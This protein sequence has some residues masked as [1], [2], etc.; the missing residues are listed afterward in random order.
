MIDAT[1]TQNYKGSVLANLL[2]VKKKKKKKKNKIWKQAKTG[3]HEK[4]WRLGV[5]KPYIF[6][7]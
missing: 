1:T 4:K 2:R 6:S 7:R 5:K 3:R